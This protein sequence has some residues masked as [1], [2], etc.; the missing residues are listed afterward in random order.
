MS[1]AAVAVRISVL[2]SKTCLIRLLAEG[3]AF[4]T[5]WSI[6]LCNEVMVLDALENSPA[7][8]FRALATPD[9][10]ALALGAWEAVAKAE[11]RLVRPVARL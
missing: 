8:L 2:R 7:R 9:R 1:P 11:D 4:T 3:T 10:L 5:C 6:W